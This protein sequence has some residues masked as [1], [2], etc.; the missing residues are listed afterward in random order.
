MVFLMWKYK[1]DGFKKKKKKYVLWFRIASKYIVIKISKDNET[2]QGS[3][4]RI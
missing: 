1:E 2:L 4:R 3:M